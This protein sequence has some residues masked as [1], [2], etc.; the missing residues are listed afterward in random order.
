MSDV[1]ASDLIREGRNQL[2]E[3]GW[4]KGRLMNPATGAV[5]ARGALAVAA[6]LEHLISKERWATADGQVT[7]KFWQGG[8]LQDADLALRDAHGVVSTDNTP[9]ASY[10]FNDRQV[11]FDAIVDWFDKAEKIAEQREAESL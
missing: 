11:S 5:C 7:M 10:L 3:R 8:P 4:N 9:L 2:F 1:K 6:G